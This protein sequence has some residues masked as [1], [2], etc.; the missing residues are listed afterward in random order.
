MK[1]RVYGVMVAAFLL[2]NSSAFGGGFPVFDVTNSMNL[3]NLISETSREIQELIAQGENIKKHYDEYVAEMKLFLQQIERLENLMSH[4]EWLEFL[5]EIEALHDYYMGKFESAIIANMDKDNPNYEANLNTILSQYG[6]VPKKPEEV[7]EEVKDLKLWTPEYARSVEK[8][9]N[10]YNR[11]RDKMSMVA[12]NKENSDLRK[13][14]IQKHQ[15][16][17]K[18]L[19]NQS[20]LKTMQALV[21][22]NLT[23]MKQ[24]EELI[25]LMNQQ[26]LMQDWNESQQ[27]SQNAEDRE[28]EIKRLKNLTPTKLHG[29]D[30]WGTF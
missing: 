18:S 17:A 16:V 4:D 21:F 26:L 1:L 7:K 10:N 3:L 23:I 15:K 5:A 25:K 30:R 22:Q 8:D 20:D 9:Y 28:N 19:K 2:V 13:E 6:T 29:K 12:Q 27:Y 14:E 24:N 11:H